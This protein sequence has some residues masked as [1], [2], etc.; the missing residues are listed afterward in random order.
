MINNIHYLTRPMFISTLSNLPAVTPVAPIKAVSAIESVDEELTS[1]LQQNPVIIQLQIYQGLKNSVVTE[2]PSALQARSVEKIEQS[3]QA[4][5]R[6]SDKTQPIP[7]E[8]KPL[9]LYD[10]NGQERSVSLGVSNGLSIM[11]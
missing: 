2:D 5:I 4:S 8:D 7:E 1:Q 9:P 6:Q 10:K 11:I 3:S